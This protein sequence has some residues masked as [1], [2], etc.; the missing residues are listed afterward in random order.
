MKYRV[1]RINNQYY[2]QY[3]KGFSLLWK[4][5]YYEFGDDFLL[6]LNP[7]TVSFDNKKDAN[8]YILL[9]E[10]NISSKLCDKFINMVDNDK[11]KIIFNAKRKLKIKNIKD[12]YEKN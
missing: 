11:E 1:K 10:L 8:N 9:K 6:G 3:K 2:P 12:I 5:F 4:D 7:T